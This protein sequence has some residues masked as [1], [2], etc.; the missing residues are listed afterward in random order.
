[1]RKTLIEDE[2]RAILLQNIEVC[3]AGS[4]AEKILTEMRKKGM[5]IDETNSEFDTI[6][7]E[8]SDSSVYNSLLHYNPKSEDEYEA[9]GKYEAYGYV[10]SFLTK[11]KIVTEVNIG[12]FKVP[13]C[14][15]SLTANGKIQF[16]SGKEPLTGLS[17]NSYEKLAKENNLHIGDWQRWILFMGTMCIRLV[18][19]EG[20]SLDDAIYAVAVDSS[21]LGNFKVSKDGERKKALTGSWKIAGKCDLGNLYKILKKD[22]LYHTLAGG[23][24][25]CSGNETPIAHYNDD[26]NYDILCYD[27][28]PWFIIY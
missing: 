22:S 15:P 10:T 16:V 12:S 27:S 26:D 25:Y 2:V 13:V 5:F 7:V 28:T 24:Y 4:I 23:V 17:Y 19:L 14:D 1:M 18:E 3:N 11:L 6:L 20:W 8:G 9:E 21:S